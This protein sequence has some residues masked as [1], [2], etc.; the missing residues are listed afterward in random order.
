MLKVMIGCPLRN[1]AWV[2]PRYLACLEKLDKKSNQQQYCFISNDCS[3]HSPQILAEFARRH[4]GE[5]RLIEK[6][7]A[8]P[9]GHRRGQYNLEH[10]AELRNLLLD[11]FLESDCDY[12][13]SLDSD[14]LVPAHTLTQLLADD[15]DIVSAL[16]CNGHEVGDTDIY[17]ILERSSDGSYRHMRNFPRDRVFPV[18]CSGAAYLIKRTV[19]ASGVRYASQGGGEDIAFCEAARSRGFNILCDGR[20]E[21]IH[22]MQES[23][24]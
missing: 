16:V 19:I 2:L 4:S 8:S 1:R 5:V 20:V 12:L 10:L 13:F 21:C 14:I 24:G 15:G 17:N 18:D 6:N 23:Q 7:Y 9:G 11:A 3:D 22:L